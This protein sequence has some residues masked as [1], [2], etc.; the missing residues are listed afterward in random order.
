MSTQYLLPDGVGL[1]ALAVLGSRLPPTINNLA[2]EQ[3]ENVRSLLDSPIGR[4]RDVF[5]HALLVVMSRL[6]SPWQ[7]IRLAIA[8]AGT[9]AIM[10]SCLSGGRRCS[11]AAHECRAYGYTRLSAMA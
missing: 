4:H 7:L 3:L 10:K 5:L 1:D 9:A 2:D 11:Y 8:A 6:T